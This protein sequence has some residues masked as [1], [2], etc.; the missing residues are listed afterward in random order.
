[1]L[2]ARRLWLRLQAL[3]D[4][5]RNDRLLDDEI[6][7][8]IEEEIAAKIAAGMTRDEARYAAMRAFGNPTVLKEETRE[9]WGWIWLEQLAQ[10][11]RYGARALVR[12][13]DSRLWR[14]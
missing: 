5:K 1:M 11:L 4:R 12:I 6:R 14:W 13:L 2:G 8:H 9:S 3:L 7:F 10:D